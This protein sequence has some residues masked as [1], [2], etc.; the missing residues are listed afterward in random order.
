MSLK[1]PFTTAV[2]A[3]SGAG[4]EISNF[5]SKLELDEKNRIRSCAIA[6]PFVFAIFEEVA[7]T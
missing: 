1:S 5:D 7:N 6:L 4:L 3:K 2:P